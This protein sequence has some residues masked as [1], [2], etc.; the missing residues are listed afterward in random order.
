MN[1]DT[2]YRYAL[3][4]SGGVIH[5]SEVNEGNR[6][7]KYYCVSCGCELIPALGKK[8][9]HH[10][11]HKVDTCSYETYLHKLA[12][13]KLKEKFDTNKEFEI[14]V[15]RKRRCERSGNCKFE[16]KEVCFIQYDGKYDLKDKGLYDLCTEEQ[17]VL[18]GRFVA[19]LLIT[20]QN[21]TQKPLL[22]EI[23]VTHKSTEQKTQSGLP[24]IEIH[25]D[26]EDQ[27]DDLYQNPIGHEGATYGVEFFN[28]KEYS[29]LFCRPS[30]IQFP[31]SK[32]TVYDSGKSYAIHP[33]SFPGYYLSEFCCSDLDKGKKDGTQIEVAYFEPCVTDAYSDLTA[34]YYCFKRGV[35]A[36]YCQ[37]CLFS[38][39]SRNG[40]VCKLFR[41]KG[42]P[43]Y[44]RQ[45][46][47]ANCGF[48]RLD[49]QQA[50]FLEDR[51]KETPIQE[52][53]ESNS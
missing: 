50:S 51:L 22:I 45:E 41:T 12:K 3:D 17:A 31:L 52:I 20:S 9:A 21:G 35:T 10:F 18:N 16:R 48:F 33:A 40:L 11:R 53:G 2:Y 19:D 13:K 44:P 47:M 1:K 49:A 25:I 30:D 27:V 42:T 26:S 32:L 7:N 39:A 4:D 37:L 23:W 6:H 46:Q 36:C 29:N 28:F 24:I 5:I 38:T 14:V 8:N 43:H 34:L 15:Q